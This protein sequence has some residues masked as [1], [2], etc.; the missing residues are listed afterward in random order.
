[1]A[2]DLLDEQ[3]EWPLV[4][5]QRGGP[6]RLG[7]GLTVVGP[8]WWPLVRRAFA[9]AAEV[10]GAEVRNVRQKAAVLEVRASHPDAGTLSRLRVLAAE[11]TEASRVR[12]EGCG[13][14]VPRLEPDRGVWRNHCDTCA[15]A[16]AAFVGGRA[17]RRL[18]EWRAGRSW[19]CSS[20]W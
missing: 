12:C 2:S 7:H 3:L 4:Q 1:M 5:W 14:A 13:R 9:A 19:P 8:G 16:L 15:A 10:P 11:L 6:W 18:W 20:F 17:E